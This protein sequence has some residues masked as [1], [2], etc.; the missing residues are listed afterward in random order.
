[1]LG[2]AG[3]DAAYERGRALARDDALALA[4]GTVANP[5]SAG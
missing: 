5:V 2:Q 3:F 1:V 4:V